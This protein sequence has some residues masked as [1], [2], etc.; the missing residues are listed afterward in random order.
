[1]MEERNPYYS[2][3][4]TEHRTAS[5]HEDEVNELV[6]MT[7]ITKKEAALSIAIGMVDTHR[8]LTEDWKIFDKPDPIV[9]PRKAR[10]GIGSY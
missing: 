9:K 5:V 1:M 6:R 2:V 7:G 4:W 10:R 3:Q 8:I